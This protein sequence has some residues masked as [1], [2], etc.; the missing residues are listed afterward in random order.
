L[1]DHWRPLSN[2]STV[3]KAALTARVLS[4]VHDVV[5]KGI[6]ITKRDLFYTD[7]KLFAKQVWEGRGG[8]RVV[9]APPSVQHQG[10]SSSSQSR[11]RGEGGRQGNAWLELTPHSLP[12]HPAQQ[13]SDAVIDD[14]ACMIGCTRSSLNVVASEKGVVVGRMKYEYL[15]FHFFLVSSPIPTRVVVG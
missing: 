5:S 6:H 3:R 8:C 9:A 12:T 7:V 4:L 11:F 15:C 1:L 14:V 10:A 2:I 13:D